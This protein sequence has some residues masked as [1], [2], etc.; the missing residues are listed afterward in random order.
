MVTDQ[1]TERKDL[2]RKLKHMSNGKKF[3]ILEL[4]QAKEIDITNLSKLISIAF[5]KC[6]NYCSDLEKEGLVVKRKEG[7]NTFVKSKVILDN[8]FKT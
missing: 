5:N 7:I 1:K 3:R 2:L 4:T 6:S 8:V